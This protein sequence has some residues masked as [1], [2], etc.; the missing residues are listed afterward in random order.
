MS[1]PNYIGKHEKLNVTNIPNV[2]YR[3][4]FKGETFM[5]CPHCSKPFK[6]PSNQ[7]YKTVM[8]FRIYRCQ[9]G[10]LFRIIVYN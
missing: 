3:N 4:V 9:C 7:P 10:E 2:L 1:N 8:G 5:A 6:L